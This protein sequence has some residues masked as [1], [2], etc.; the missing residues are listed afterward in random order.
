MSRVRQNTKRHYLIALPLELVLLLFSVLPVWAFFPKGGLSYSL[1]W[2]VIFIPQL[3]MVLWV[4]FR[5]NANQSL[6][7]QVQRMYQGEILKWGVCI[8]LIIGVLIN[9]HA[10]IPLAFFIGYFVGLVL[11]N[12]IP[13]LVIR[14]SPKR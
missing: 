1:G 14:F 11:N 10:L 6:Q 4:F 12:L 7:Q 2:G 3:L 8:T 13:V 9:Y 5:R